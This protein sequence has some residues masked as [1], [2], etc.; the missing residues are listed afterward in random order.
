MKAKGSRFKVQGE[1]QVVIAFGLEPLYA[2][3]SYN[4]FAATITHY[5][6]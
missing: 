6:S 1:R 3:G 2:V 4:V 5:A